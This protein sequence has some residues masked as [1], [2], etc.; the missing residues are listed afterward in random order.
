MKRRNVIHQNHVSKAS[1][2]I[3]F[4]AALT[5]IFCASAP[6]L[7][8]TLQYGYDSMQRLTRV[9]HPDGTTIDYDYDALGNRLMKT[10][11]LPGGP[12]NQPPAAVTSPNPV[13]NTTNVPTT[14]LL[15]WNRAVDPNSGDSVV[16]FIYFGTSPTPPLVFSGWTTNCSPGKLRGFTTYYWYVVARDSHNAQTASP[17]WSF[18]TGATPPAPDFTATPTSGWSR[19]SSCT[20]GAR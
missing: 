16:Y 8:E 7:A 14:P 17:V 4:A 1:V 2:R 3:L 18:T 6:C 11:T 12:S 10:T 15:S 5:A 19:W 20:S 13:N 9:T